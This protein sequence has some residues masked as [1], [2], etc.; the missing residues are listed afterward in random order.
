MPVL[1]LC[2]A[3]AF[4]SCGEQGLLFVAVHELLNCSG[5]ACTAGTGSRF[6][7]FSSCA[8][9]LS[10]CSTQAL[11][12]PRPVIMA[13]GFSCSSAC[14]I[15]SD[16][17]SN[18][19]RR[20]VNFWPTRKCSSPFSGPFICGEIWSNIWSHL[21]NFMFYVWLLRLCCIFQGFLVS[22][23]WEMVFGD[24]RM[25]I[26]DS[27]CY[28]IITVLWIFQSKEVRD[29]YTFENERNLNSYWYFQFK[30]KI[31]C[32]F[33]TDLYLYITSPLLISLISVMLLVTSLLI[34][35]SLKR[36][37]LMQVKISL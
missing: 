10:I 19:G 32:F 6:V 30:F 34:S 36:T 24:H 12:A 9:S 16:Q 5:F 28:W 21:Q 4:S 23:H 1:D 13:Y 31:A 37:H 3:P 17:G 14:R 27:L 20:T 26:R 2:C 22:F 11:G 18:I 25:G 35:F 8:H 29:V 33:L 15:F 7:G